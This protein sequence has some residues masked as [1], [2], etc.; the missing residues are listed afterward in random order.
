MRFESG[1]GTEAAGDRVIQ[2]AETVFLHGLRRPEGI[3]SLA[4][5]ER[6]LESSYQ[7]DHERA[8]GLGSSRTQHVFRI[9]QTGNPYEWVIER[10][11]PLHIVELET[12][13]TEVRRWDGSKWVTVATWD[14]HEGF[15]FSRDMP[16]EDQRR[17]ARWAKQL[18]P[19]ALS[20][21]QRELLRVE[22]AR[23]TSRG[24][25]EAIRQGGI[26]GS[27]LL[28]S[29]WAALTE[30]QRRLV[31]NPDKKI[32]G[33]YPLSTGELS[34]LTGMTKRKVQYWSER[35]LLP[36]WLDSHGHRRFEAPGAIVAFALEGSKQH[37]RQHYAGI[38]SSK[39]PL[40]AMREA[41]MATKTK[42]F[43][44]LRKRARRRDPDWDAK[45]TERRRAME[46]ALALAE[47][48]QSRHIT[49]VQLADTLGISQGNVSRVETRSD[50]YLSTLR[51]YIEALGGQLEIAAVFPDERVA[52]ALAPNQR[53][54]T[55]AET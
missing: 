28:R 42:N 14:G 27:P 40:A 3:V 24:S 19:D 33:R 21:E 15:P 18:A 47:L 23:K 1:M 37:D 6:A 16:L 10:P 51:S 11:A 25:E 41:W 49:Q 13:I 48:R 2:N 9:E 50:V 39:Q 7:Q 53:E 30:K 26:L 32:E 46:D 36:H 38:A 12:L 54:S 8:T 22:P 55:Q 45:V 34:E 43:N 52:V 5:T 17:V 4:G 35:K 29:L 20:R 44:E 31:L